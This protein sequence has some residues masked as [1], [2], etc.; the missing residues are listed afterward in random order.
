MAAKL[1]GYA[2]QSP[3]SPAAEPAFEKLVTEA[4]VR[5]RRRFASSSKERDT[6][7]LTYR[8]STSW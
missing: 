4:A 3:V 6:T 1:E 2:R 7:L 8:V 5:V